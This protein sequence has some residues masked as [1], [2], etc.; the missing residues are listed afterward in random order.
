ML[1]Q[2]SVIPPLSTSTQEVPFYVCPASEVHQIVIERRMVLFQ[3]H[4]FD[5]ATRPASGAVLGA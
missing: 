1:S 2:F 3:K 5:R 4:Q